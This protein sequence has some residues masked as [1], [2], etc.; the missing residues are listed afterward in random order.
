M[1]P[2]TSKC[3]SPPGQ[4]AVHQRLMLQQVPQVCDCVMLQRFN[5]VQ[6]R[7]YTYIYI[8]ILNLLTYTYIEYIIYLLFCILNYT[9]FVLIYTSLRLVLKRLETIVA[10]PAGHRSCVGRH[11]KTRQ[12]QA[13]SVI[14]C[15]NPQ[16]SHTKIYQICSNYSI[17]S[18]S[19]ASG[20]VS[21]LA[22]SCQLVPRVSHDVP[23]SKEVQKAQHAKLWAVSK[24]PVESRDKICE[25]LNMLIHWA[26]QM[27]H[28]SCLKAMST[29]YVNMSLKHIWFLLLKR[30]AVGRFQSLKGPAF[31]FCS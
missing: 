21:T 2:S 28:I 14:C 10:K 23:K 24:A 3:P 5:S 6:R 17:Y 18:M 1:N 12:R 26:S 29:K 25:Q 13:S 7:S 22:N 15:I 31:S 4:V 20:V 27:L 19:T 8:Y 16:T 9:V 30:Q 11:H